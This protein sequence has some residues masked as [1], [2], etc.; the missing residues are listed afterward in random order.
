MN[1]ISPKAALSQQASYSMTSSRD[2]QDRVERFLMTKADWIA[3][4]DGIMAGVTG[5]V[6]TGPMKDLSMT[7]ASREQR[8]EA[9]AVMRKFGIDASITYSRSMG[10][11]VLRVDSIGSRRGL[12]KL[13]MV[14]ALSDPQT[15][16]ASRVDTVDGRVESA[17][18]LRVATG[19]PE[20]VDMAMNLLERLGVPAKVG[21]GIIRIQGQDNIARLKQAFCSLEGQAIAP[22]PSAEPLYPRETH[23]AFKNQDGV[24]VIRQKTPDGTGLIDNP[25]G[26]AVVAPGRVRFALHGH[27]VAEEQWQANPRVAA[28]D[29]EIT[30]MPTQGGPGRR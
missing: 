11:D 29:Q 25:A 6:Q 9:L 13:N 18:D 4:E 26:P 7:S 1:Q 22:R 8:L 27:F 21:N 5:R 17:M 28:V 23:D 3:R 19:T 20:Q 24:I 10:G 14:M 16:R 30:A 15:W 12:E 2:M